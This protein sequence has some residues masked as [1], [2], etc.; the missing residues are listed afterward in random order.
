M[1]KK[2]GQPRE[3]I[4]PERLIEASEAVVKAIE[5]VFQAT[6]KHLDPLAV[7]GTMLQPKCL[8]DFTRFEVEEAV[9]FLERLGFISR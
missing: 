1:S 8:C 5:E 6:G 4:E 3:Q 7:M 9:A 2:H